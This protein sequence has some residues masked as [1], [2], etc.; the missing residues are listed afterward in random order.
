M[1]GKKKKIVDDATK[2]NAD[3]LQP[4]FGGDLSANPNTPEYNGHFHDGKKDTW[5]HA[6]KIN[7]ADHTTGRLVLSD[8]FAVA[9][10][11]SSYPS[12]VAKLSD[13]PSVNST[14][15]IATSYPFTAPNM[16][17]TAIWYF[18]V[19]QDMDLTKSS[20]F[21]F[22]W[23]G[24]IITTDGYGNAIFD[25]TKLS[26]QGQ[27]ISQTTTFRI[28]WQWFTPGYSI[29]PPAVVYDGY[30]PINLPGTNINQ[31]SLTRGRIP[32]LTVNDLPFRLITNDSST[33]NYSY[34]NLTGLQQANG[35]VVLGV[36]VD[37]LSSGFITGPSLSGHI[38]F[39]QGNF[40][41]LSKI[42][43]SSNISFNTL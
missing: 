42:L 13:F 21:S 16:L 37:V 17:A 36:Q 4:I 3:F 30:T 41:Y 11:I 32:N 12:V 19:P 22:Q 31:N 18:A 35:A 5:G 15:I 34:V 33:S 20:Y 26:P 25:S 24:D 28:T 14:N 29:Y 43:G 9:K 23:M 38:N 10:N 2:I 8:E 27:L 40:V 7:L 39:F 1:A 6:P